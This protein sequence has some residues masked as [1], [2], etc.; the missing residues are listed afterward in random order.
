MTNFI[1]N[2][3]LDSVLTQLTAI[4]NVLGDSP[5]GS[6]VDA[7]RAQIMATKQMVNPGGGSL[8]QLPSGT[9]PEERNW[10]QPPIT[11]ERAPKEKKKKGGWGGPRRAYLSTTEKQHLAERV[12][13]LMLYL[14]RPVSKAEISEEIDK[15]PEKYGLKKALP[16][17]HWKNLF[18]K[19]Q[20]DHLLTKKGDR[21]AT[22]YSATKKARDLAA[23]PSI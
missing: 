8:P 17:H 11:S 7:A 10:A 20:E 21:Q 4:K 3:L 14:G 1:V 2:P 22:R 6:L 12:I 15:N 5:L 23:R 9:E 13:K 16:E 18:L 19:M